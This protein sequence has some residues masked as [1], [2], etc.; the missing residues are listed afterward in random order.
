MENRRWSFVVG[1]SPSRT[2]KL[3]RLTAND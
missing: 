1:R 2:T 3:N